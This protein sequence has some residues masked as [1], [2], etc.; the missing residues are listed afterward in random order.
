VLATSSNRE[1][2][3]RFRP[4]LRLECLSLRLA[5]SEIVDGQGRCPWWLSR[6]YGLLRCASACGDT[7][8]PG[9]VPFWAVRLNCHQLVSN[10]AP[11]ALHALR[12]PPHRMH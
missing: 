6:P 5:S 3:S 12:Y 11:G 10:L 1:P 8:D 2:P 9:L 7:H 4:S